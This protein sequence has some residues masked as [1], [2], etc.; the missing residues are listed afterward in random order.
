MGNFWAELADV[1]EKTTRITYNIIYQ[2]AFI[3]DFL[4]IEITCQYFARSNYMQTAAKMPS[5]WKGIL[6]S[7]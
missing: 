1:I 3:I 6:I 2:R 7:V 4:Q 5:F